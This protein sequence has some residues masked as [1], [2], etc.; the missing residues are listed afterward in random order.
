MMFLAT[1]FNAQAKTIYLNTGGTALWETDGAD[2]FAVWHWQGSGSGQFTDWMTRVE[3][4]T[5]QVTIS[6]ASDHVIFCRCATT[7]AAAAWDKV[8]NQTNDL[9][10][11]DG[12]DLYTITGWGSDKSVG[13]WS[14]YGDD[15]VVP[16]EPGDYDKAV[17]NEC[18]DVML[19]AFYWD[20]YTD[21]GYGDTRW[22]TLTSQAGEIGRT[23]T[24][25]WLPP[26]HESKGG[27]G[28]IPSCYS[29]QSSS[30][31]GKKAALQTLITS[32]HNAGARVIADI[33]I[34]HC[35]NKSNACDYNKLN[36]GEYGSFEPESSWM[37]SNDEGVTQ[38]HCS[39]GSHADD[40][41]HEANYGPARDWDHK[42]TS[43]QAMCRA[44]LKWMKNEMLYDGFR[45]DYCGGY[46]TSHINDYVSAAKPYFSVMEY[47][48]GN[49]SNLKARIDDAQKNT[50]TFD[51]ANMYN[52]IR[53]GIAKGSFTKCKNGGLRGLGYSKYAVTFID[54]HD[55]FGRGSDGT[56]DILGKGDGSSVNNQK[57]MLQANAYI[58][59][60][61]GV[62][63]VFYP[64]WVKYKTEIKKMV[65][66]RRSAGIHSSSTMTETA[67][68]GYYEA[69]VTGKYGEV[70][71]YLG[72]S[73]TK[74]APDGFLTASKGEGYAMYYTTTHP[75]VDKGLE[76]VTEM[77]P[78]LD[79]TEPVY[80]L[81]GQPVDETY[82]GIVIQNGH[83][84]MN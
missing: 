76:E 47:W 59:S 30:A 52:A 77:V 29:T 1:S 28:Y 82:H 60:L 61:P 69:T 6:D 46:H 31:L 56:T 57:V 17:P 8:W 42:N 32:L 64:H 22:E 35:G 45:F 44:Y 24:L 58:L 75:I 71:L 19:Q 66:A 23:F 26:S 10:L 2:K 36:F 14:T 20:S 21:K 9:E 51:F 80:N 5:W 62:P 16:I 54:N 63:C 84:Y 65:L 15:P 40:G 34:N 7:A 38:Y 83:K 68:S 72:T 49:A 74:A 11:S 3:G 55:T 39:G 67:G 25:V 33:V 4:S 37:T 48:D 53:D 18:M 27:L 13:V 78:A 81:L 70:I 50:L 12:L 43:V 41:Q 73:A 79:W